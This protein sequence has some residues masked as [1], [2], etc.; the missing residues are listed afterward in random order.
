MA[1]NKNNKDI[2]RVFEPSCSILNELIDTH[3]N[4]INL[5]FEKNKNKLKEKHAERIEKFLNKLNDNN[6][7]YTDPENN[8]TYSNYKAYKMDA[9]KLAIYNGSDKKKLEA[10]NYLKK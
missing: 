9:I 1:N 7:K 5:S 4:E 6:T 10:L 2:Q 3:I 8:R